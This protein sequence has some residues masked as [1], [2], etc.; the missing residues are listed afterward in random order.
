MFDYAFAGHCAHAPKYVKAPIKVNEIVVCNS[1]TDSSSDCV[2][3]GGAR[4][5]VTGSYNNK[6]RDD[7]GNV[8]S[9][10]YTDSNCDPRYSS[11]DTN[12]NSEFSN[13]DSDTA[14]AV[15]KQKLH[16][17]EPIS[18][19][20]ADRYARKYGVRLRK[21][22]PEK[23]HVPYGYKSRYINTRSH[24]TDSDITSY[25]GSNPGDAA[26]YAADLLM[27][28]GTAGQDGILDTRTD[29]ATDV[30]VTSTYEEP[31]GS[32]KFPYAYLK[33]F[34]EARRQ[35]TNRS[36]IDECDSDDIFYGCLKPEQPESEDYHHSS[37]SSS[38]GYP[39]YGAHPHHSSDSAEEEA[40]PAQ[41]YDLCAQ[42]WFEPANDSDLWGWAQI[43]QP[44][45]GKTYSGY[46]QI[47]AGFENLDGS[48]VHGFHVHEYGDLRGG[49]CDATGAHYNPEEAPLTGEL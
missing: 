17:P 21:P 23:E 36:D 18:G 49:D 34:S 16:K 13:T 22:L 42:V 14:S 5:Q 46:S 1:D 38:S 15:S 3:I 28:D 27:A 7:N 44:A 12:S 41:H 26:F 25:D 30:L 48:G 10:I 24:D 33:N 45:D 4:R 2:R 9:S 47:K 37:E 32:G 43:Y 6:Q 31:A 40:E 39:S 35:D 8:D 20:L 29:V 11:C 19:R